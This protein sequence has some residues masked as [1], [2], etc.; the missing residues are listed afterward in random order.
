MNTQEYISSGI[1]EQY[2]TGT[3]SAQEKQEV[4]C[5]SHI[6]PEIAAELLSVQTTMEAFA[7]SI[8]KTPPA[9]LRD[10]ILG[11]LHALAIE[12]QSSAN[13]KKIAPVATS[14]NEKTTEPL[15]KNNIVAM[16]F[17]MMRI[18][19]AIF[20]IVSVGL[21]YV[22]YKNNTTISSL[23][24]EISSIK[25]EIQL[26]EQTIALQTTQLNVI[27]NP[28][29]QK[30][31]LAGIATKS[32]D[33]KAIIYWNK[34]SNDVYLSITKLPEPAADKQYQLWA[35][36]DGKPVDMGMVSENNIDSL[37]QKMK[38]IG[39]A[40]AFAITLEKKGGVPSPTLTEMYVMG[41]V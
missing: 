29:V 34:K 38:T 8:S 26:K 20:F 40:Q 28:D 2:V 19:A 1:L 36:A 7:T 16:P 6:Y 41:G 37:F 32:P 35:I 4:E 3:L 33:S 30:V 10:K 13:I 21:G 25:K 27:Q 14:S 31:N 11:S 5:M 24:N 22:L 23:G 39:N 15:D 18:A 9:H 12:E 17:N